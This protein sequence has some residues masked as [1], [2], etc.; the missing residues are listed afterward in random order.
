M[1]FSVIDSDTQKQKSIKCMRF[2]GNKTGLQPVSRPVQT[3]AD[4]SNQIGN[5]QFID[6]KWTFYQPIS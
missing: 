4:I 5:G 1:N 2:T 6:K 3:P